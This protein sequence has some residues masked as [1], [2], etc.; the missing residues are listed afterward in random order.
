MSNTKDNIHFQLLPK[1][2]GGFKGVMDSESIRLMGN[3]Y[4]KGKTDLYFER[5]TEKRARS[6]QQN[7]FYWSHVLRIICEYIDGMESL[8]IDDGRG[9]FDFSGAHRY[10][11]LRFAI[12]NNRL[13]LVDNIRTKYNGQWIDVPITSFSFDKMKHDDANQY[14][15]WLEAKVI[16]SV[17]CGFN[18]II[19]NEKREA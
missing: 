13:D 14:M 4:E 17:G 10:L 11:T 5:I 3:L 7:A 1:S 12:D 8:A 16:K 6:N 2:Q 15:K 18:M 19:E 9:S